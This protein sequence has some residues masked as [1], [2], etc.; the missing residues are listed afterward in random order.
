VSCAQVVGQLLEP[1]HTNGA[2]D[3]DP[4][5]PGDT[6]AHDPVE[7]VPQAPQLGVAQHVPP[8]QFIE[9]H[10]PPVLHVVP[11]G[12]GPVHC[13]PLQVLPVMQLPFPEHI[14]GHWSVDPLH[15]YA[16]HCGSLAPGDRAVHVPLA[17]VPHAPHEPAQQ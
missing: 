1:L 11:L 3:G 16:P 4:G 14:V 15:R 13:P 10:C 17:Q 6:E 12:R 9:L 5:D 7:Q 8:T 2:H